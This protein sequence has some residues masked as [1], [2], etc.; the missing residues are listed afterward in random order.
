MRSN[1]PTGLPG[2]RVYGRH[3]VKAT[4]ESSRATLALH[5]EGLAGGIFRRLTQRIDN[6]YLGFEAAGLKRRSEALASR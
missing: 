6:Q 1:T 2:M 5:F 4:D 3:S